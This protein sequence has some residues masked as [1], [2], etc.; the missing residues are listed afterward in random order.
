LAKHQLE[1][2]LCIKAFCR[3]RLCKAKLHLRTVELDCF[4]NRLNC[5]TLNFARLPVEQ[6]C[7]LVKT[8]RKSV[9]CNRI[10]VLF[11]C[12]SVKFVVLLV[13][14]VSKF[15]ELDFLAIV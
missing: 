13:R 4:A 7:F 8:D 12:N 14:Q 9:K 15:V 11:K 6:D 2:V 10:S 1:P 3:L 5:F